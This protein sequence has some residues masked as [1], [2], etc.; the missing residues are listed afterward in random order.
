MTVTVAFTNPTIAS[1]NE[2]LGPLALR[3][4]TRDLDG[5]RLRF[6]ARRNA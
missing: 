6:G 1:M 4:L 3:D 5:L 2:E